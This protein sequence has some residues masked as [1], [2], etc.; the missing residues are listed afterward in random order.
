MWYFIKL[1]VYGLVDSLQSIPLIFKTQKKLSLW[2][3]TCNLFWYNIV[4]YLGWIYLLRISQTTLL[5]SPSRLISILVY[6]GWIIPQYLI[7]FCYNG[8][9]GN[10]LVQG[11]IAEYYPENMELTYGC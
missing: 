10:L 7:S 4:F 5:Q 6:G 3:L 8:Y 11:F 2:E 1:W 9:F